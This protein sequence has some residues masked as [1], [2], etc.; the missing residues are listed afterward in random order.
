MQYEGGSYVAIRGADNFNRPPVAVNL[1]FFWRLL[2]AAGAPGPQ[3]P[4]GP[5]GIQGL[6]GVAGATG[7]KG[8]AG[9]QGLAGPAGPKGD[10]GPQGPAGPQSGAVIAAEQNFGGIGYVSIETLVQANPVTINV[11]A[12]QKISVSSVQTIGSQFLA[13]SGTVYVYVCY[14]PTAGG[15][16]SSIASSMF[17]DWR[18]YGRTV[19]SHVGIAKNIQ[20]GQ[21][22]FGL[23]I[24]NGLDVDLDYNE[25]GATT[26]L[27]M[28]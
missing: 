11:A 15:S 18:G 24:Q 13:Q 17:V 28:N 14:V 21:Y 20:A 9:P 1:G 16:F 26:V 27:V 12:G 23:C 22:N 2:A 19:V 10:T 3:G 8:D 25:W 5:Q 7:P 6:P 4:Q